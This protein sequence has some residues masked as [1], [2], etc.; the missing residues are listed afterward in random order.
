MTD[1]KTEAPWQHTSNR[2]GTQANLEGCPGRRSLRYLSQGVVGCVEDEGFSA[3]CEF[4][5][6][7]RGIQLPVAA[8]IRFSLLGGALQEEGAGVAILTP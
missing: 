5:G 1:K 4:A 7:L 6:Q 3:R 8:G 2:T